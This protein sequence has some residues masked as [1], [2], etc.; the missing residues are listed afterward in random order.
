MPDIYI[1][2]VGG[3]RVRPTATVTAT[4]FSALNPIARSSGHTLQVLGG[5]PP[6]SVPSSNVFT[7]TFTL[8][9]SVPARRHWAT[10]RRAGAA[11]AC[12]A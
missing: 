8:T 5:P 3:D 12:T 1:V 4:V 6:A 9:S 11:S 2:L 10:R 7:L